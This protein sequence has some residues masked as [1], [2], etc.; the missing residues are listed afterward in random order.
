MEVHCLI[1]FCCLAEDD[2][3]SSAQYDKAYVSL[4]YQYEELMFDLLNESYLKYLGGT[5]PLIN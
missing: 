4:E 2:D 1:H 5:P 3:F